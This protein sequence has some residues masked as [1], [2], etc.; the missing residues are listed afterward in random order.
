MLCPVS[1][2]VKIVQMGAGRKDGPVLQ[3]RNISTSVLDTCFGIVIVVIVDTRAV[4]TVSRVPDIDS[5]R[6]TLP[7]VRKLSTWVP[8]TILCLERSL[9]CFVSCAPCCMAPHVHVYFWRLLSFVSSEWPHAADGSLFAAITYF[10]RLVSHLGQN[11]C[12]KFPEVWSCME[13]SLPRRGKL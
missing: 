4:N 3:C 6:G 2:E 8:Q 7:I 1:G 5:S 10:P 13:G 11:D 9:C 12:V